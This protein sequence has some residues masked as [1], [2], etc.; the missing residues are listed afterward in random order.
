MRKTLLITFLCN[1]LISYAQTKVVDTRSQLEKEDSNDMY[2]QADMS[3]LDLLE[4]LELAGIRVHKFNIGEMDKLYKFQ[5]FAEEYVN[6]KL[7]KT[8]T[9]VD[10]NN[11][12]GFWIDEEYNP[13]Y[14]DQIK[15]FTKTEENFAKINIRTY[16]MGSTKEINLGKTDHRQF[17]NWRAYEDTQWK[18]NENVPL[19]IF[20]SSWLDKQFNF[21]RF[22]GVVN[23]KENDEGT[24]E[25]LDNSP[26][27]VVLSFRIS[28]ME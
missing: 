8:D 19:L 3:T 25:L 22:C 5:I 27:Y 17:Y 21:H 10:Y 28:E 1:A 14:I 23:L 9:L 7:I 18:L 20:A 16:A 11:E 15:I 26:N 24:Q 6:S 4:A 13:A 12:Y 2:N